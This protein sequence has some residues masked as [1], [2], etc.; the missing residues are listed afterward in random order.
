MPDTE[1]KPGETSNDGALQAWE[2][3]SLQLRANLVVLSACQT[4]VGSKV[5]GEGLVGLTRAFQIAGAASIVATQ[6]SVADQSTAVGMVTFH[7]NL[8]KGLSKDEALR[9]AMRTVAR[10]PATAHPSYWAPFVLVG[11]FRPLRASTPR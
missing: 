4:G 11:D 9:Q 5:A 1:P 3:I 6:W 10:D 2:V 8:L 7:R